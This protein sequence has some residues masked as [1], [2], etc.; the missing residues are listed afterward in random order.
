MPLVIRAF[1]YVR[2]RV[3]RKTG[4]LY[5]EF[6]DRGV[7]PRVRRDVEI[8]RDHDSPYLPGRIAEKFG[9][10]VLAVDNQRVLSP[11]P[12]FLLT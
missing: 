1:A 2:N 3:S 7:N 11:T 9:D 8:L 5:A 10:W 4:E 12:E 6:P